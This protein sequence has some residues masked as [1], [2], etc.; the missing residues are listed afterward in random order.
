MSI[1]WVVIRQLNAVITLSIFLVYSKKTRSDYKNILA[2]AFNIILIKDD[3]E[4]IY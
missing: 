2:T 4:R 3:L 1:V